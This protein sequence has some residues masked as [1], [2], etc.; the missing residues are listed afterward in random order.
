[1]QTEKITLD[2]PKSYYAGKNNI[3]PKETQIEVICT[4]GER[5]IKRFMNYGEFLKIEKKEGWSY[6]PY[7]LGFSSFTIT[8]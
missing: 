7:Q 2:D 3:L 5:V 8:D 4:K 1:M 6:T